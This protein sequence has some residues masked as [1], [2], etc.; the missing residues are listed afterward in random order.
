MRHSALALL[1]I[2][3]ACT[4]DDPTPAIFPT[5]YASTFQ[6]VRDCRQSLE[7]A[8]VIRILVSP[9]AVDAYANRTVPFPVGA[10]VLKEQYPD[11]DITCSEP[12]ERYTVMRKLELGTSPDTLDWEWQESDASF[13]DNQAELQ[14]C[15]NCHSVCGKGPQGYDGTC[16]EPD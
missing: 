10:F 4:G 13:H 2:A 16:S 6:E 14:N 1:F 11:G 9:D 15:V 3:C 12:V 5:T 7:H 8:A